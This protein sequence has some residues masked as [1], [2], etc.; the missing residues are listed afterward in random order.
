MA[1]NDFTR[2]PGT[3]VPTHYRIHLHPDLNSCTFRF[4]LI[5]SIS[6]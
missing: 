3:L 1:K 2:L 4:L 6:I 5:V